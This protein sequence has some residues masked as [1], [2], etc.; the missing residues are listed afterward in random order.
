MAT[1]YKINAYGELVR[2][3]SPQ[4]AY[5]QST[6]GNWSGISSYNNGLSG[7]ATHDEQAM[8]DE[9]FNNSQGARPGA[10]SASIAAGIAKDGTNQTSGVTPFGMNT[11][12]LGAG[13]AAFSSLANAWNAYEANKMAKQKF[14]FEKDSWQKNYD[15]SLKSYNSALSDRAEGMAG[16]NGWDKTK[17]DEY[18]KSRSL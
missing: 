6:P 5:P 15:N 12:T 17:T 1:Q 7:E 11:Q 9:M 18:I 2:V 3:E 8:Q 16:W 4:Q 10:A 13:I 14:S